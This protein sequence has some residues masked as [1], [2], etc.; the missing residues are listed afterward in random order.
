M[1]KLTEK[2]FNEYKAINIDGFRV[3]LHKIMH[4]FACGDEYPQ[5]SQI[6]YN[7]DNKQI[8]ITASYFKFYGGTGEYRV[9][10]NEFRKSKESMFM[11]G[12]T[13]KF[14]KKY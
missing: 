12:G 2:K 6:V 5:L 8:I 9:A 7:D 11:M 3:D 1:A 13:G 4:Q 14:N 10:A